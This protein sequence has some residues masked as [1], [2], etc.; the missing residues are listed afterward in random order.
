MP[1]NM[2]DF[3]C[4]HCSANHQLPVQFAGN[5]QPCSQCGKTMRL[6]SQLNANGTGDSSAQANQSSLG[7]IMLNCPLCSKTLYASPEQA[8]T[9]ILCETCLESIP[10]PELPAGARSASP[11]S[12]S[13]SAEQSPDNEGSSQQNLTSHSAPPAPQPDP[14]VN[15]D[16]PPLSSSPAPAIASQSSE[17]SLQPLASS[18]PHSDLKTSEPE[19]PP[20]PLIPD[21]TR[22][23]AP[24]AP[25]QTAPPQTAPASKTQNQQNQQ[26]QGESDE[27]VELEA[28]GPPPQTPISPQQAIELTGNASGNAKTV[29]GDYE[30]VIRWT[31]PCPSC[32]THLIVYQQDVGQPV[33]CGI[34]SQPVTV[35]ASQPLP[36]PQRV[37]R[38]EHQFIG[39]Q[40]RV[41]I[42]A[43]NQPRRKKG[44]QYKSVI[45]WRVECDVCGTGLTATPEEIGTQKKCPDCFKIHTIVAPAKIP[46]P[47]Q[48]SIRDELNDE[49]ETDASLPANVPTKQVLSEITDMRE[50]L[51]RD[52]H[53]ASRQILERAKEEHRQQEEKEKP[54]INLDEDS[55]LRATFQVLTL[56]KVLPRVSFLAVC[57]LFTGFLIHA[58]TLS[59]TDDSVISAMGSYVTILINLFYTPIVTIFAFSTLL[60]I[61]EQTSFGNLEIDEWPEFNIWDF[62]SQFFVIF[63]V[64]IYAT[65]PAGIVFAISVALF[66]GMPQ[67]LAVILAALTLVISFPIILLSVM[68]SGNV[69]K[70]YSSVIIEK[71]R[72][73]SDL[74]I[75]FFLLGLPAIFIWV[76]GKVMLSQPN[77]F[78]TC[79]GAVMVWLSL[80][81]LCRLVGLLALGISNLDD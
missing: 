30:L 5:R 63:M 37:A 36:R 52:E 76:V 81:Y 44:I 12:E 23:S 61:V 27:I 19:P 16:D 62:L 56:P 6:P 78:V 14:V 15:E 25:P 22:A 31:C 38:V 48:R 39:E 34:C 43:P 50:K 40:T 68:E 11:A 46:E 58:A 41:A 69:W 79:I 7:S 72:L 47:V 73:R 59:E 57:Y 4:P 33:Q 18:E 28:V 8:G 49:P 75:K 64:Y 29:A 45:E 66:G 67:I 77:L 13:G 54:A 42:A 21:P 10:V 26:N 51:T 71:L 2:L 20:A 53:E 3:Q 70:P 32:Q 17:L 24:P 55:W 35:E 9:E 60:N 65:I 1:E 80:V 74:F